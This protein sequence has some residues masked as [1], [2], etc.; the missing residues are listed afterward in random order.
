MVQFYC[1]QDHFSGNVV[2]FREGR[3]IGNE[4][5][6]LANE[7][8]NIANTADTRF[9]I[10]SVTKQFTAAAILVLQEQ[11]RHKTGDPVSMY[12]KQAPAAWKSI[13]MRELLLHTSGIPDD[14]VDS[15]SVTLGRA[16]HSPQES[17]RL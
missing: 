3:V 5:G 17:L 7:E 10:G 11:G 2:V 1:S 12:Y 8:W 14:L 13:T 6:G 4:S 9:P 16:W 15:N